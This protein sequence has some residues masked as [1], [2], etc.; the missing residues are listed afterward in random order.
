MTVATSAITAV[1][2]AVY[3]MGSN[4]SRMRSV[5]NPIWIV[6]NGLGPSG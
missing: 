4:W 3:R 6:A 2:T 5:E 1:I